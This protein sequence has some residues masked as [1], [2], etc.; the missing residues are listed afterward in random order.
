MEFHE[1]YYDP[2]LCEFVRL[3]PRP[4]IQ[5]PEI[6]I[7]KACSKEDQRLRSL[8]I[9]PLVGGRCEEHKHK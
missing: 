2:D 7:C 3:N 5:K 9:M 6:K 4:V 8:G 1:Q